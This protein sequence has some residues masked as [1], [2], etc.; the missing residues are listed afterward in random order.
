MLTQEIQKVY[1]FQIIQCFL[2]SAWQALFR[3]F[4]GAKIFRHRQFG[5][6]SKIVRPH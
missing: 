1:V 5:T 2:L 4:R 6:T 3:Q